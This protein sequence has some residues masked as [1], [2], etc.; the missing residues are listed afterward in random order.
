MSGLP[1]LPCEVAVWHPGS[2]QVLR[3]GDALPVLDF[4]QG[5]DPAGVVRAVWGLTVW[6][7]HDLGARFGLG[8]PVHLQAQSELAPAG[9]AWSPVLPEPVPGAR[10]WQRP[11]WPA[12]TLAWLDTELAA[13]GQGRR[14]PPTFVSMHDLNTVWEVSLHAGP[15]E[16][17]SAFLKV[18][19]T[20]RE[21]AVTAEVARTLPTL[22][23]PL[24][25]AWPER[26]AQL[27]AS[28]GQLLDG[29]A[30]LDAWTQ[31]L[32]RLADVQRRADPTALAA[33]G[34]PAWPLGRAGEAIL[35][36]LDDAAALRNWNLPEA[37]IAA[38]QADRSQVRAL[39]RDLTAHGL[40]D[41]PSHGDAHPR[42]ALHGVRGSVWFDWSE[43]TCAAHPFM[44]AG[45][46]LAFA[47]H[48]Q[49]GG[50][51]VRSR[52]GLETELAGAFLR[53]WDCPDAAPL[54]WRALPLALLHRAVVYDRQFRDWAGT[55]PGWR[56]Q[57]TRFA[58]RQ[59]V[60]ELTRLG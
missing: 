3:R 33:A 41:R 21:A 14:G 38:L 9:L 56:P 57:Y 40:P 48:P 60:G 35:V 58:L 2:R 15:A 19:E 55:V 51:P 12:H 4:P 16:A 30:D 49:R 18:S 6:P 27:V 11:G 24:L 45:W 28:G 52:A 43:A 23:P 31:A 7:L 29:V 46:F 47:L 36:L 20:G 17:T 59:A 39:L 1:P 34:C 8:G 50:L 25:G 32:T 26:G 37:E 13:R 42:N 5:S 54:L 22:V 44:D 10:P 53:A